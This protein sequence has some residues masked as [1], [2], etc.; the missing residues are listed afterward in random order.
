VSQLEA[1]VA[2]LAGSGFD[3]V[4]VL[5]VRYLAASVRQWLHERGVSYVDAT[6]N[7][8]VVVDKLAL[9]LL[10]TGADRDPWRGLGRPRATLHGPPAA[11]M[12]RA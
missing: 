6:G 8:R 4:P 2:G 10:D 5:V 1:A 11:R 7:V 3:V 12:V 9:Y